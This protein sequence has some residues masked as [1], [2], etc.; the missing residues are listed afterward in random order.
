MRWKLLG[1]PLLLAGCGGPT[2][3]EEE[4]ARQADVAEVKANQE[5]PPEELVLDAITFADVEQADL[6]GAGCNVLP[7]SED[8]SGIAVI[9]AQNDYAYFKRNGEIVR[10]VAD[11]GSAQLPYLARSKYSGLA[12]SLQLELDEGAGVQ[13]GDET[14][15]YPGR[16][17]ISDDRDRP[18]V[19]D[20]GPVQCGA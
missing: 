11:A 20:E 16:W 2:A 4:A 17:I 10:L 19:Q 3:T 8:A 14:S 6:F 7:K 15:D 5:P 12:Y 13:S 9:I 1:L 18:V